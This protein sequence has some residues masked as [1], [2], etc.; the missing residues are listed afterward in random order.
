MPLPETPHIPRFIRFWSYR[1]PRLAQ[2]LDDFDKAIEW[3]IG[4]QH[5]TRLLE[6]AILG[7]VSS[8][9]KP[10]SPAGEAKKA[11]FNRLFGRDDE[12]LNTLRQRVL[13]VSLD[14]LRRVAETWLSS[15]ERSL[16]IVTNQDNL[17]ASGI[18]D[19]TEVKL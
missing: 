12:F 18:E 3:V 1:D 8:M 14:D 15:G 5:Q 16:G 19:L 17:S 7:V 11:Y 2:T 10:S 9:D 13:D 6:E 4:E